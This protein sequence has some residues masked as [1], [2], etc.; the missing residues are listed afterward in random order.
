MTPEQCRA[1]RALK[2]ISQD[3]LAKLSGIAIS[4]IVPFE[5]GQRSPRSA[6]VVAIKEA[7][8]AQGIEFIEE[9]GGGAG[10]RLVQEVAVGEYG[11]WVVYVRARGRSMTYL[12]RRLEAEN[13]IALPDTVTPE[14]ETQGAVEDYLRSITG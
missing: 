5:K 4:T 6:T 2:N 10:V 9:N 13:G 11:E 8:E 14:M 1:A 12:G 3:G 7:L